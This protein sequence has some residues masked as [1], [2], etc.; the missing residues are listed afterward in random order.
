MDDK[1]W[2]YQPLT[3]ALVRTK[4]TGWFARHRLPLAIAFV[5]AA[6]IWGVLATY[7]RFTQVPPPAGATYLHITDYAQAYDVYS[8]RAT[9]ILMRS[10]GF[11]QL[12]LFAYLGFITAWWVSF[13]VIRQRAEEDRLGHEHVFPIGAAIALLFCWL[14]G[15]FFL[16]SS[17]VELTQPQIIS[18]DPVSDTVSLNGVVVGKVSDIQRFDA[19]EEHGYRSRWASFGVIWKDG[20]YQAF[21]EGEFGAANVLY[22]SAYLN[23]KLRS[24][25]LIP[26]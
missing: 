25:H 14:L 15:S 21:D 26:D 7:L 22:I 3:W 19:T 12:L 20:R 11:A 13:I 16:H 17:V 18:I 8:R 9:F 4:F 6:A 24:R 10:R 1:D 5:V 23:E 2:R